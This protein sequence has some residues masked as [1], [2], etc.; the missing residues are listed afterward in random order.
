MATHSSTLARRIPW[1]EEPCRLQSM[2]WHRVG[3][4]GAPKHSTASYQGG[5]ETWIPCF[6]DRLVAQPGAMARD[7]PRDPRVQKGRQRLHEE[8][9]QHTGQPAFPFKLLPKISPLESHI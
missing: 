5:A 6:P 2:G 9:A 8:G 3:H 7:G 4:S 1:I